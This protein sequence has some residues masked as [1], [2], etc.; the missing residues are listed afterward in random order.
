MGRLLT[1]S[2]II[3]FTNISTHEDMKNNFFWR[4]VVDNMQP[5]DRRLLAILLNEDMIDIP[6]SIE[7]LD[8]LK[9]VR[10]AGI[11]GADVLIEA[12]EKYGAIEVHE[13][14]EE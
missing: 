8:F 4:P 14:P 10:S 6:L 1:T 12:I 11:P 13:L 3:N 9:G 7:H 5:V 2:S